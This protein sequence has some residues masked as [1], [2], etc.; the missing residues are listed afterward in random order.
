[1][2]PGVTCSCAPMS[3]FDVDKWMGSYSTNLKAAVGGWRGGPLKKGDE[4]TLKE[5]T[6]YY[7]GWL[8][9]D[10]NMRV[11]PWQADSR[12]TYNYP[13]EIFITPGHEWDLLQ[14]AS[15][16]IFFENNFIIHPSSDR[17]GYNL[18]S[19]PLELA[20][21]HELVSSAV[22]F[23]TLQLLPDGQLIV[24]MADHQT[25]GGYPRIGHV[26]SAHLPKLAQLR[27]SDCIQFKMINIA[28][29]ESLLFAQHDELQ[30]LQRACFD[31]LKSMVC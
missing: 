10:K 1:M 11:L 22:N 25:T 8:K 29:A 2:E 30:I 7:A 26:I 28:K 14:P 9:E 12:I 4:L 15:R 19:T 18:R 20:E 23:G 24:L 21:P 13:H 17:M 27:P 3:G 16:N 5:S 31:H 6:I